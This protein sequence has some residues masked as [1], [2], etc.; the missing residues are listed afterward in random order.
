MKFK[1]L[2]KVI[3]GW[4]ED[5]TE[6]LKKEYLKLHPNSRHS[7]SGGKNKSEGYKNTL[8]KY[9]KRLENIEKKHKALKVQID[10]INADPDIPNMY[11]GKKT[12]P[13]W[14]KIDALHATRLKIEKQVEELR[15]NK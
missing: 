4:W 1:K 13:L 3:A 7:K 9:I 2:N 12:R 11:R 5:L 15:K 8:G 6:D 10:K 14:N